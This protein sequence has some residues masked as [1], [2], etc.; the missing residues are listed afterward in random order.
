MRTQCPFIYAKF[1]VNETIS[2]AKSMD[3]RVDC[4]EDKC[5][6]KMWAIKK[7]LN[8]T[9]V[10]PDKVYIGGHCSAIV[11]I[12]ESCHD[13]HKCKLTGDRKDTCRQQRIDQIFRIIPP[14][15]EQPPEGVQER[16][17]SPQKQPSGD[18][19]DALKD[20]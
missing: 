13:L 10:D 11:N 14:Q 5:P 18:L 2:K 16:Q 17:Y 4:Y 8:P 9:A 7:C 6:A 15:Q 12:C 1:N 19:P 20:L 3:L